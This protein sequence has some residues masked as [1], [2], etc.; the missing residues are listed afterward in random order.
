MSTAGKLFDEADVLFVKRHKVEDNH[1]RYCISKASHLL[2]RIEGC[3][4]LAILATNR[5]Q[6]R[7]GAV[8]N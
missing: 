4:G 8:S 1:K 3:R 5:K 2:Q 6:E 7:K